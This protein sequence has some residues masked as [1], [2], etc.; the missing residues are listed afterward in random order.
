MFTG[1]IEATGCVTAVRRTARGVH[2][3]VESPWRI[4]E[5][6]SVA[7]SGVC[8]T[9][10]EGKGLAFDV[11]PETLSRTTLGSLRPGARVNLERALAAG[12]RLDGHIVQG[13]VDGRGT[14]QSLA[15]KNGAVTLAIRTPSGLSDQIVPKGSIAVDGVSLTVVDV[16][17]GGF[18]VAL[19]PT[20]LRR[21]TLGQVRRGARVNLETDVLMKRAAR[22]PE[23]TLA[24]LKRAGFV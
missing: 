5:G 3:E 20:T 13:H 9:A 19:I 12:A 2:L 7:V 24:L 10:L 15:R 18:T 11:I 1:I 4:P 14:V 23:V 17:E 21:T 22:K 6:A 16:A 8:L